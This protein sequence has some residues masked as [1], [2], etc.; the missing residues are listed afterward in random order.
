MRGILSVPIVLALRVHVNGH[1]R[2]ATT[3]RFYGADGRVGRPGVSGF[4]AGMF[5]SER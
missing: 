1:G 4:T 3:R 5:R 2:E